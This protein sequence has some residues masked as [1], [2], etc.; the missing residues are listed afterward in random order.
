[1]RVLSAEEALLRD[2]C[3]DYQRVWGQIESLTR[4]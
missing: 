1:M 2:D 4:E 3:R